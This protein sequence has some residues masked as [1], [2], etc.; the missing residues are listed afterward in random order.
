MNQ[1]CNIS[2]KA[3]SLAEAIALLFF[4]SRDDSPSKCSC[5]VCLTKFGIWHNM[6]SVWG[7]LSRPAPG[8]KVYDRLVLVSLIESKVFPL[9]IAGVLLKPECELRVAS[10]S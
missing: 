6:L 4:T 8:D 7:R 1:D 9:L 3:T 10:P 2:S 5:R